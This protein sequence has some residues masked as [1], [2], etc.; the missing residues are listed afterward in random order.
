MLRANFPTVIFIQIE[1]NVGFAK[2][3]NL[4]AN[5]ATGDNLL[6]LNPDTIFLEDSPRIMLSAVS[7]LENLGVAGCRLLNRDHTLQTTSVQAFPTI[8]NQLFDSEWLRNRFPRWRMWGIESLYSKALT[9]ARVETISGA[10]M[11]LPNA[12]F[13]QVG[14]FTESYFMYAEDVDLCFKIQQTG[15]HVYYVPTTHLV[16]LGGSSS[17]QAASDFSTIMMRQSI[18]TFLK[19]RR[20]SLTAGLYRCTMAASAAC[21]ISIL[22]LLKGLGSKTASNRSQSIKKWKAVLSWALSEPNGRAHAVSKVF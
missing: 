17:S 12:V 21:R 7:S 22:L 13:K 16:H 19:V 9:P 20:G 8:L 2:A 15:R 14:G 6:L 3:N 11:L 18:F 5:L 4:A 1:D 10:C